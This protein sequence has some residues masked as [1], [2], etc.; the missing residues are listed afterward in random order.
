MQADQGAAPRDNQEDIGWR[1]QT[2]NTSWIQ[3]SNNVY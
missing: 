1:E 3:N 2:K